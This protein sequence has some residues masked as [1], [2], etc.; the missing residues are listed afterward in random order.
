MPI[1]WYGYGARYRYPWGI[2][3]LWALTLSIVYARNARLKPVSVIL[4]VL[5]LLASGE[6]FAADIQQP[7]SIQASAASY[8]LTVPPGW[9][10]DVPR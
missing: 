8:H 5:I 3:M 6:R 1:V 9:S 7:W 4:I 2:F 10:I